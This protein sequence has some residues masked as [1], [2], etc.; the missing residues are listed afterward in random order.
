MCIN[1]KVYKYAY[2]NNKRDKKKDQT[3]EVELGGYIFDSQ[4]R[5]N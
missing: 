5:Q 1:L 4:F 3:K 2:Y